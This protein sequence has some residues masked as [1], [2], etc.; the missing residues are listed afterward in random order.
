MKETQHKESKLNELLQQQQ[1][2]R[3]LQL[4]FERLLEVKN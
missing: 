1:P 2:D 4:Y 3:N